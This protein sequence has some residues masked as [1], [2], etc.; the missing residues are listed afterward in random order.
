MWLPRCTQRQAWCVY[1]GRLRV[2]NTRFVAEINVNFNKP[3]F[4][5]EKQLSVADVNKS[6][7]IASVGIH[8]EHTIGRI[9]KFK[10]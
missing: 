9:K 6:R 3:D 8:V 10:F 5:N 1:H 7:K 2:Y 4:L